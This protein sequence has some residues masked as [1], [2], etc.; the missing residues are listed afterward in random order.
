MILSSDTMVLKNRYSMRRSSPAFPTSYFPVESDAMK[1]TLLII[2]VLLTTAALSAA[3]QT[4][5]PTPAP[6][7]Q[8]SPIAVQKQVQ[9]LADLQ[10]R[11]RS[12]LQA[13]ELRRGQVGIKIVSLSTGKVIF[14]E[15]A[16]KY[17]MPASNMKNFTVATAIEKLTPDFRFV[18]SVY[19]PSTPD[20]DGVVKGGLRIF[21][22]GDVS[23][24][25]SFSE[26]NYYKGLDDLA[27]KI[28]AAGVKRV[29]GDLVADESYR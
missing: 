22:R 17:F 23:I 12:R 29:E 19:A 14:E 25:T 11:I 9:T 5:T 15:N 4:P 10:S 26:G 20:P 2:F 16:E 21:G 13:P 7:P 27:D 8:S 28:V 24:S 1:E 6:A 18:T 3:G